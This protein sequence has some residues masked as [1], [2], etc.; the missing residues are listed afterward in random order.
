MSR[1]AST[2]SGVPRAR[3]LDEAVVGEQLAE[4]VGGVEERQQ[5]V[6]EQVAALDPAAVLVRTGW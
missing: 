3:R 6:L 4:Q 5:E 2:A 1:A